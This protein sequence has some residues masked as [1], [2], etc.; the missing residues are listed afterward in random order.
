MAS[1]ATR[2]APREIEGRTMFP[3]PDAL[4]ELK[5]DEAEPEYDN[6]FVV[7]I[8]NA[9]PA[10]HRVTVRDIPKGSLR[11]QSDL[12][13]SHL[14]LAEDPR[15]DLAGAN[16]GRNLNLKFTTKHDGGALIIFHMVDPNATFVDA[17]ANGKPSHGIVKSEGAPDLIFQARWVRGSEQNREAI[18]VILKPLPKGEKREQP[19]GLGVRI[20]NDDPETRTTDIIIDPKVENEGQGR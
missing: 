19:Y 14:R 15:T 3:N 20:N 1:S 5:E 10:T 4:P 11:V 13:Q 7:R 17:D 6:I 12:D 18:S 2:L 9:N 16:T 8:D